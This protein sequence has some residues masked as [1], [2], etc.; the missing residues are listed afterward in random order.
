MHDFSTIRRFTGCGA[1]WLARLTG[2]Q[3]NQYF[4]SHLKPT[5]YEISVF[6]LITAGRRTAES[7]VKTKSTHMLRA[8]LRARL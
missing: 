7:H 1:V 3:F 2:G 5:C 8:L 6:T 4:A